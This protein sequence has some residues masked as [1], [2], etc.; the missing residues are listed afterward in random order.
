MSNALLYAFG[1]RMTNGAWFIDRSRIVN[2]LYFV[3]RGRAVVRI[4]GKEWELREGYFYILPRSDGFTPVSSENFDHTYFD[5][6]SPRILRADQITEEALER[7]GA[8]HFLS[9][10]NALIATEEEQTLHQTM[11]PFLEAFL[12]YASS[13][14]LADRYIKNEAIASAVSY[15]H[16]SFATVTTRELAERAH[17]NESYFIRLFRACTGLSPLAYVRARRVLH[18]K[19]LLSMGASVEAAAEACG[20][21]SPSAFYKAVRAETKKAPSSLKEKKRK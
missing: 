18:G 15:I 12:S 8:A 10:I 5:Y 9:F 19:H 17:L 20:Y 14:F 3:N 13:T 2:R 11:Q 16:E 6:Y 1:R 7:H 4:G 21:G